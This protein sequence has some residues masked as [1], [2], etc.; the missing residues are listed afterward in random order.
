MSFF[1][2]LYSIFV[3]KIKYDIINKK[4]EYIMKK[5]ILSL[6][7]LV[8]FSYAVEEGISD[9]IASVMVTKNIPAK[10][11]SSDII[12]ITYNIDREAVLN[13]IEMPEYI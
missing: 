1:N 12:E 3:N 9:V 6:L 13:H 8:S 7:T 10:A 11:I 5:S 4:M 2:V